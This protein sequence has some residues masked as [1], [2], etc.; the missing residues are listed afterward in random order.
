M[1]GVHYISIKLGGKME[2][3]NKDIIKWKEQIKPYLNYDE[4]IHLQ[5]KKSDKIFTKMLTA[6]HSEAYDPFGGL[7]AFLTFS[8]VNV[9]YSFPVN[10]CNK[11]PHIFSSFKEHKCTL[12]QLWKSEIWNQSHWANVN[13][14]FLLEALGENIFS[15]FFQLP[16][17]TWFIALSLH[18]Y[19][20]LFLLSHLLP[21]LQCF[22]SCFPPIRTQHSLTLA[23]FLYL[24]SRLRDGA[25]LIVG[26][27]PAFHSHLSDLTWK[28]HHFYGL[29]CLHWVHPENRG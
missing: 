15:Y 24:Q 7:S 4:H 3:K 6:F 9:A 5:K 8:A 13:R 26:I 12:L 11:L 20:L 1:L 29:M 17:L 25:P 19:N 21:L 14:C 10:C 2:Q 16:V 23:H 28:I 22:N 27:S 18:H